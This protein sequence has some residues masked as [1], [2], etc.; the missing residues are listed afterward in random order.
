MTKIG[1]P[2]EAGIDVRIVRAVA[3]LAPQYG[4][5]GLTVERIVKHART[6]KPAFYRRFRSIANVVPLI[7]ASDF[8]DDSDV[9]TGTLAGDLLEIQIRQSELFNHPLTKS[10]LAGFL[11]HLSVNPD[12]AQPFIEGYLAPRRAHTHVLL[13]RSVSRGEIP[14]GADPAYV[15]DLLTGPVILRGLLPGMPPIDA[16]LIRRTVTTVLNEVHYS[17]DRSVLDEVSFPRDLEL[18]GAGAK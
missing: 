8:G 13:A 16:E 1:R 7:L 15:A 14:E 11:D 2:R 3:E 17:G 12:D 6:S 10:V 5:S 18:A 4:Y 9:D